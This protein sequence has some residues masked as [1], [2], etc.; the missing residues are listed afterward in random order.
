MSDDMQ[1]QKARRIHPDDI[2]FALNAFRRMA[3]IRA[4]EKRCWDL[5]AR[6]PTAIAGSLHF[7]AGQE[8]IPVG[9]A[10]ALGPEDRVIATYRGHGW[11]LETRITPSEL[12]G[13]I[14]HRA[15]GVNG[16]RAG[17]AYVMAPG[18][19]FIG[20]NS[21][22]GAGAP[23]ACGVALAAAR[24]RTGS[25]VLVSFGDGATSQGALHE[26][27][28]FAASRQLPVVFLCESNGWSEMTPTRDIIK[29]DRLA[30][31]ASGYGIRSATIDGCDPIA[32]R[33]SVQLAADAARNGEGPIFIEC[34]TVRLWGHYNRDI[35]HY[36]PKDDRTAAEASDPIALLQEK[37]IGAG[38]ASDDRLA[39]I[40][41]GVDEE[42]EALTEEALAAPLPDPGTARDH[43][44]APPLATGAV[45]ST[46]EASAREM[47]FIEAVNAALR[48]ELE[49]RPEAVI[50]G[51]DVGRAG[52]IFGATRNL[53]REFGVERVFDTP[54]AESAILGSGVGA[55]MCGLRPIVEIMW[56]DFSLVALDQL[57]NQAANIR[58][59]TRGEC[60]VPMVVR[61]QQGATPGS[62]AQHSQSLEA[63]LTH[64]PG[65]RVGL[66]ATPQDAY[67][68]LRAA[69]AHPD[70]C[71]IIE[72]RA[73]YQQRG[74]VDTSRGLQPVGG[75]ALRRSGCDAAIICW[76]TILGAAIEAAEE[77]AASGLKVAVLDLRW[78]LPIDDAAID[79]VVTQCSGRVVVAHEANVTGG[80][81][82]EIV[83][84]IIERNAGWLSVMPR[85]IGAPDVRIPASP[86][87]QKA[88]LP[89]R[90]RIAAAVRD[91]TGVGS[92]V[93]PSINGEGTRPCS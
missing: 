86:V 66:P 71:I 5:S 65:L 70:P 17:S 45:A 30:K 73:L 58:Y 2:S 69:V 20:E 6:S 78:L 15:T 80:M 44:V 56:A 7:C 81:G 51:E 48:I 89:D 74:L 90:D 64:V 43:V 60:S 16:G 28:V 40:R 26:A 76:S 52:G 46:G 82:A 32:V 93:V 8:A 92:Q 37:L 67:D 68:M 19:G 35:E 75:A 18:R 63:L 36:R 23:I 42:I 21:I 55:A 31:R 9:A 91:I 3:F 10:A 14:C 84:R 33:D 1:M 53:Q 54:I 39:A 12:L 72:A 49:T 4:F 59:V 29:I 34:R 85:R 88:L 57:I 79:E 61:M 22:V 38:V 77:L 83:A 87:L 62:C 13:E 50:Y 41:R 11:A 27:I 47:S 24:Q 25:V